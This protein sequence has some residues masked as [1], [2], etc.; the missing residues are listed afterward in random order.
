MIKCWFPGRSCSPSPASGL[1]QSSRRNATA[2]RLAPFWCGPARARRV[3][4]SAQS[5]ARLAA[6]AA[7]SGCVGAGPSARTRCR[8]SFAP[9]RALSGAAPTARIAASGGRCDR[10]GIAT[11]RSESKP[12]AGSVRSVARAGC[13]NCGCVAGARSSAA[14]GT[15]RWRMLREHIA[16]TSS[17]LR[18][19]RFLQKRPPARCCSC[20]PTFGTGR[21]AATRERRRPPQ[22]PRRQ[23]RGGL[24]QRSRRGSSFSATTAAACAR[25]TAA[26]PLPRVPP[27]SSSIGRLQRSASPGDR[28]QQVS[29]SSRAPPLDAMR[30][31]QRTASGVCFPSAVARV[32]APR[33][34]S[35][36]KTVH[37]RRE[38]RNAANPRPSP[39][40]MRRRC[41]EGFCGTA[42]PPLP[43]N[44]CARSRLPAP[45]ARNSRRA[46]CDR[47]RRGNAGFA[48]AGRY[49]APSPLSSGA[50]PVAGTGSAPRRSGAGV[51]TGYGRK[52]CAGCAAFSPAS[53]STTRRNSAAGPI[54]RL[55][56]YPKPKPLAAS[57]C[58]RGASQRT[59]R[60]KSNWF[61]AQLRA[62]F[63]GF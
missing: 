60:Q 2:P 30:K 49:C 3:R 57:Y 55:S 32:R 53:R 58:R 17:P 33:L 45:K 11:S 43:T 42:S 21:A 63:C 19:R 9:S 29:R 37:T 18:T 56:R 52:C 25:S 51:P 35:E 50:W 36:G 4:P 28:T 26:F 31:T 24:R 13:W 39:R 6:A 20:A 54:L 46:G 10:T 27:R 59:A 40:K 61:F 1:R 38:A 7:S 16:N 15:P 5:A 22:R 34:F 62:I 12:G 8:P 48:S 41:V 47:G 44:E 14:R 23:L